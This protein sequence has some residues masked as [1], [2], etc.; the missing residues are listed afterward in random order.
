V[1]D[2]YNITFVDTDPDLTFTGSF[3]T[4]GPGFVDSKFVFRGVAAW[5][6]HVLFR[7]PSDS[8]CGTTLQNVSSTNNDH[9]PGKWQEFSEP[10]QDFS[11]PDVS[12][13]F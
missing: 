3:D 8:E 1:G 4:T 7:D 5:G 11:V 2:F 13:S 9:V 12:P 10:Q 6:H